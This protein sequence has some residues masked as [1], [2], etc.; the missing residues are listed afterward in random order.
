MSGR[1]S[2]FGNSGR[3][4][5]DVR[6]LTVRAYCRITGNSPASD[7]FDRSFNVQSIS[8][9]STELTINFYEMIYSPKNL[10]TNYSWSTGNTY[11]VLL[12]GSQNGNRSSLGIGYRGIYNSGLS[13]TSSGTLSGAE[14]I[15]LGGIGQ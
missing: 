3:V 2:S 15:I 10:A 5:N 14:V 1:L 6:G 9:T 8:V 11:Y 7:G 4:W 13:F 12:A